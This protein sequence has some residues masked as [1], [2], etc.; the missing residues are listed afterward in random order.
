[1]KFTANTCGQLFPELNFGS[2]LSPDSSE[3]SDSANSV[4]LPPQVTRRFLSP[5]LLS[6]LFQPLCVLLDL[7]PKEVACVYL[8]VV[9]PDEIRGLVRWLSG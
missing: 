4:L 3:V 9:L 7:L 6:L 2:R 5:S 8:M 1:M